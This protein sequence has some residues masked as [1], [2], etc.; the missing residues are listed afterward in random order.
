MSTASI[1]LNVGRLV[2][3]QPGLRPCT[4][5]GVMELLR[6]YDI[7]VTGA[8]AVVVGRRHRRQAGRAAAAARGAT[9]AIA[10]SRPATWRGSSAGRTSWWP[11]SAGPDD[12]RRHDQAGSAVIDVGINRTDEGDGRRRRLRVR[13]RGGRSD[14]AGARRRRS[15]DDRHA[16]LE[17]AGSRP[18][19]PSPEACKPS[20]STR[21]AS[22]IAAAAQ[23]YLAR[24]SGAVHA[25]AA[26]LG[27]TPLAEGT[28]KWFSN[29]KG[30]G[31]IQ[32]DRR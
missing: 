20:H 31:F 4:P 2:A 10:H 27:G 18:A 25:G 12:H 14:H 11:P 19:P 29:E 5:A 3:N 23:L 7:P 24:S 22:P 1:P 17:Y 32:Q 26:G 8:E 9:V 30:Y 6:A 13:L 21:T 28:V 16:A 15:N